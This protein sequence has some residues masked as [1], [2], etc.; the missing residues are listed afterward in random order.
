M[1]RGYISYMGG[2]NVHLRQ[3]NKAALHRNLNRVSSILGAEFTQQVLHV[4]FYRFFS[5]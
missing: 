3:C 2:L 1:T 4:A 5:D